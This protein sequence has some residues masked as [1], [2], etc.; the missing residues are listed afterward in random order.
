M[1]LSAGEESLIQVVR[2]LPPEDATKVVD[3]VQN[4]RISGATGELS[5]RLPGLTTTF[6]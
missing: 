3:W 5:G 1:V 4:S 2:M 6:W